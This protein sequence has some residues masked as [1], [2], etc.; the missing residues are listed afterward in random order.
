MS[1]QSEHITSYRYFVV[2]CNPDE[3]YNHTTNFRK[4][5]SIRSEPKIFQFAF[6]FVTTK[7]PCQSRHFER[8]IAEWVI[9]LTI[10]TSWWHVPLIVLVSIWQSFERNWNFRVSWAILNKYGNSAI[11]N[12]PRLGSLKAFFVLEQRNI[13]TWLYVTLTRHKTIRTI[14]EK[15]KVSEANHKIFSSHSML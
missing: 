7:L 14:L 9:T 1:R 8:N 13:D 12:V 15:I 11:G 2:I 5:E 4:N 3:T 10:L 6:H